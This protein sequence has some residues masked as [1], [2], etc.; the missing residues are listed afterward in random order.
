MSRDF[1]STHWND[2][3]GGYR[4][5]LD[6][7]DEAAWMPLSE[8]IRSLAGLQAPAGG[9]HRFLAWRIANGTVS[10]KAGEIVEQFNDDPGIILYKN[11]AITCEWE[12][13]LWKSEHSEHWRSNTIYTTGSTYSHRFTHEYRLIAV[14]R[15]GIA[16][17]RA[18]LETLQDIPRLQ[19]GDV[20]AAE[21]WTLHQA[22]AWIATR[23]GGLVDRL[24]SRIRQYERLGQD[25]HMQAWV[26][27]GTEIRSLSDPVS[28]TPIFNAID[29]ARETLRQACERGRV[30][31]SGT[32]GSGS[33]ASIPADDFVGAELWHG[34]GTSLHAVVGT[35]GQPASWRNL[36]FHADDLRHVFAAEKTNSDQPLPDLMPRKR[37]RPLGSVKR[38]ATD[39][40]AYEKMHP[41]VLAGTPIT[42]AAKIVERE[43]I[44]G[45]GVSRADTWRKNYLKWADGVENNPAN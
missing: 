8:A 44:P 26:E 27:L 1:E 12:T 19:G 21:W 36:R 35:E 10:S 24:P 5:S 33:R 18:H 6:G 32:A 40:L 39:I 13:E 38:D 42:T 41:L 11:M 28:A 17:L 30:H 43:L 34:S 37:G 14:D 31:A 23:D 7:V 22:T 2:A 15:E 9:I 45:K 29:H 4:F 25:G 3:P 16:R 20:Q